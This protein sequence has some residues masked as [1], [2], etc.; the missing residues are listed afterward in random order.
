MMIGY[1]GGALGRSGQTKV[2][3]TLL[4]LLVLA[5]NA[6][7][8]PFACGGG[9]L[10]P[11]AWGWNFDGECNVP[12]GITN[13]IAVAAGVNFSLALKKDGTV[14]AW[15]NNEIGQC[16]VPPGLGNVVA[17]S[18]SYQ[19][20]SLALKAD[21]TVVGWGNNYS[22]QCNPP[23]GLS[24]VVRIAAGNLHGVALKSDGTVVAWGD[25]T[26]GQTNVPPGLS[27]VVAIAAADNSLAVKNDGTIV[28]WGN[29]GWGQ[30]NIPAGLSNVV[31]VA[32]S[33]HTLALKSDG[34]VVSWGRDDYG[35]ASLAT[36]VSN[37]IAI[38]AGGAHSLVLKGDGTLAAW[39]FNRD[40]EGSVPAGLSSVTFISAK[41]IHNI[42]IASVPAINITSQPQNAV[43]NAGAA[44]NFQVT[45]TCA[46]PLSYQWFK[47]GA[48]LPGGNGSALTLTNVQ[49]ADA[50]NYTVVVS[51]PYS[52][53]TSS[54]A[55]LTIA[56]PP[57]FIIQPQATA[58]Y[59]R[60]T[61]FFAGTATSLLPTSY[62]WIKN[63]TNLLSVNS[64]TLVL[65]PIQSADAGAYQLVL[66]SSAGSVTSAP[67]NL[68]FLGSPPVGA[69]LGLSSPPVPPGLSNITAIA[70]GEHHCL[71]LRNDGTVAAWTT[72]LFASSTNVPSGLSNVVAIAAGNE[73]SFAL[74][75]DGTVATW[76]Y[77][78][79]P[80]TSN[81]V[82]ISCRQST[83]LAL[84]S[85]G[86]VYPDPPFSLSNVV[87]IVAGELVSFALKND[88]TLV[89]WGQNSS[90]L[91]GLTNVVCM[92]SGDSGFS[93]AVRTDGELSYSDR[94]NYPDLRF[95]NLPDYSNVVTVAAGN[96]DWL[97]LRS[98]TTVQGSVGLTNVVAIAAANNYALLLVSGGPAIATQPG[99]LI[100]N[101]GENASFTVAAG[102]PPPLSYQWQHEGTNL[103]GASSSTLVISNAQPA[104]AGNY[105]VVVSDPAGSVTSLPAALAV[106][107]LPVVLTPPQ[108][109]TVF[110]GA[111]LV[112]SVVA[113]GGVPLSFQWQKDGINLNGATNQTLSLT[114]IQSSDA[115]N[116]TVVIMNSY[117]SITSAPVA[118]VM[119]SHQF[120]LG[121]AG[122]VVSLGGP[123]APP[124]LTNIVSVAA[125]EHHCL[126]LRNDGTVAAW[127]PSGTVPLGISN[128]VAIAAGADYSAA[129]K[130]DGTVVAWQSYGPAGSPLP[131]TFGVI[132]ISVRVGSALA[133]KADGT[134]AQWSGSANPPAGLSNVTAV[135]ANEFM[136]L[137]LKNDGTLVSWGPN[138]S[139]LNGL[140]NVMGMAAGFTEFSL[141][142]RTDGE[143]TYADPFASLTQKFVNLPGYSNVVAVAAGDNNWLALKSDGTVQGPG[144]SAGLSNVV[145]IDAGGGLANGFSLLVTTNPP[146]P[147]LVAGQGGGGVALSAPVS[148]SGYVLEAAPDL[149]QPFTVIETFTNTAAISNSLTLPISG[150]KQYY[151]LR[152]L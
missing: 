70:A 15:G 8:V 99:N 117:G 95:V 44:V 19:R 9:P 80:A 56:L 122:T 33:D 94:N 115:G 101:A 112:F 5:G 140:T 29:N 125:G 147:L 13:P 74:K 79:A 142:A 92:A 144:V 61:A 88:G 10:F 58:A 40:G 75:S 136:P 39:G 32:A 97:A 18:A 25:N 46:I 148:V 47:N 72:E 103:A 23:P 113:G 106:R 49:Q 78:S 6:L 130:A 149:S 63:G 107:T 146:A 48:N 111:R 131:D 66:S 20:F 116:Y 12:Q 86:T 69:V 17:I 71:A 50:A 2:S 26:Y 28:A 45:A 83:A 82:A 21:G 52:S 60:S 51:H 143:L 57:S 152:K 123:L 73:S 7:I 62:S 38:S 65:G 36:N 108:P 1:S 14:A 81:V 53:V 68:S 100:V 114:G 30:N 59:A 151:R 77:G 43:T 64:P 91:S 104:D 42:A 55:T 102:G 128:V 141:A 145:A 134:V 87:A 84:K 109:Q 120:V 89:G 105:T 4:T 93:L 34:T 76:G 132:A 121:P 129:L 90:L 24:N 127:G 3:S 37:V 67:A 150:P 126:A 35:Q 139:R 98:D 22:G 133:L 110:A 85:D 137:A 138:P 135:A 16:N 124:G 54:V 118:L 119:T 41:A 27:G 31:A 11:Q 96:G